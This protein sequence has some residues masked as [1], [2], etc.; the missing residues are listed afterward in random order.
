MVRVIAGGSDPLIWPVVVLPASQCLCQR[1]ASS[2]LAVLH[3]LL[4][5][6]VPIV[7]TTLT[8]DTSAAYAERTCR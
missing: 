8:I 6:D 4:R 5:P 7:C 2:V 3:P 1:F